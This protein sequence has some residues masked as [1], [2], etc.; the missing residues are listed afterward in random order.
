MVL[1]ECI[2]KLLFCMFCLMSCF[3]G[4]LCLRLRF[5]LV[6]VFELI[7]VFCGVCI[8]CGYLILMI[9]LFAKIFSVGWVCCCCL[10][11]LVVMLDW[12]VYI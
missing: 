8:G 6:V 5:V 9:W 7:W 4:I 10:S 11:W 2:V 1:W 12:C 3:V